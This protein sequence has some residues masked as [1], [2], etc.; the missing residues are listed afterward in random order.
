MP[1]LDLSTLE[2]FIIVAEL[3][4]FTHAADALGST[5]SAISLKLKRLEQQLGRTLLERTPRLVRLSAEGSNFLPLAKEMLAANERAFA[6]SIEPTRRLV[7]GMSEHVAGPEFPALLTLLAAHDPNLLLEVKVGTSHDIL[8][9]YDEGEIDAAIVRNE[10]RRK[11]GELLFEDKIG[12]FAAMSTEPNMR[13]PLRL[14]SLT[15]D[16]GMRAIAIKSLQTAKIDWID[17]FIGGGIAATVAATV[18]GLGIAPLAQRVAPAG[19]REVG[20][21]LGLPPLPSSRV[22]LYTRV[23][24]HR[25]K[26]TL[27]MLVAAFRAPAPN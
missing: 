17:A 18:A 7:L 23:A 5:Q 25:T 22:M 8:V 10:V 11:D 12:W 26:G 14:I 24:D 15:G 21:M 2:A 9:R 13:A 27:R 1:L 6:E 3:R 4:S 19:T 16:C 20:A